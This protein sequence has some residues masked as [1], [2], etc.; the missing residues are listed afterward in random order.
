MTDKILDANGI[1]LVVGNRVRFVNDTTQAFNL[2][3]VA[4]IMDSRNVA[5]SSPIFH[6]ALAKNLV[7]LPDEPK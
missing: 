1:E 6:S 4:A 5:L 7:I 2:G 3:R